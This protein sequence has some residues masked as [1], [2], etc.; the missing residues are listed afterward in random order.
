MVSITLRNIPE[1]ILKRIRIFAT[2]ERRSL[3]SEMLILIENGL[4][5]KITNETNNTDQNQLPVNG[6]ISSVMRE[7]LW[8]EIAGEWKDE[9]SLQTIISET[10][11][12]RIRGT[13]NGN[14]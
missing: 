6:T 12:S 2:R 7:K 11:G 5:L 13:T 4:A 1:E 14:A 10:Y 3:N 9:R 8:Q